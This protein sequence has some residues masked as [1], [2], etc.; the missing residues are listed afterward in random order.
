MAKLG[1][2]NRKSIEEVVLE[3]IPIFDY[4]TFNKISY[5][6]ILN[7]DDVYHYIETIGKGGFGEVHKV[8]DVR[9]NNFVA[10]K[11]IR[12]TDGGINPKLNIN[13][14]ESVRHEVTA[15]RD[16]AG[17]PDNIYIPKYYTSFVLKREDNYYYVIITEY[18]DGP[19]IGNIV[20]DIKLRNG[21][22]R[23]QKGHII[24]G[25]LDEKFI[26]RLTLWFM[27]AL[28]FVH[29]N[30]WAH[31]D[32]KPQNVKFDIVNNRYILLDFGI[33]CFMRKD[34][35]VTCDYYDNSGTR[36]YM[37][38]ESFDVKIFSNIGITNQN[39]DEHLDVFSKADIWMIGATM[40]YIIE[41]KP[42]SIWGTDNA[43]KITEII[44]AN[45]VFDIKFFY[46]PKSK[47]GIVTIEELKKCLQKYPTQRPTAK[48]AG[49]SIKKYMKR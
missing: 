18:I 42:G 29:K 14:L 30:N 6:E 2:F 41:D 19:E 28:A 31:R 35:D 4:I 8:I 39:K 38:P 37:P 25:K 9:T 11:H 5:R 33:S 34:T 7:Y 43:K 26:V 10:A 21:G 15:Y 22:I 45:D 32:I 3:A 16:L 36:I 17:L 44:K 47:E 23:G 20:R 1:S 40:Y 12:I 13:N 46:Q 27:D 49:D 48:Q 24:G